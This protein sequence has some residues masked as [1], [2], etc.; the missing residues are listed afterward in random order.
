[1]VATAEDIQAFGEIGLLPLLPLTKDGAS[2]EVVEEMFTELQDAGNLD[3][4]Q[5]GQMIASLAFGEARPKDQ[6]WV[7]P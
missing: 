7:L 4:L 3:L 6:Q 5:L 1:M 2:R